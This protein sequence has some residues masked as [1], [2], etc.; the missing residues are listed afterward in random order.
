MFEGIEVQQSITHV[1][2]SPP[3][4]EQSMWLVNYPD[5]PVLR[6]IPPDF[7]Q[8]P[9]KARDEGG[10]DKKRG[11][12]G[13]RDPHWGQR[14]LFMNELELLTLHGSDGDVV[15]YAGAAPGKH[16]THLAN[17]LF[18]HINFVLV[19]PAPFLIKESDK[20]K[21]IN[22]LMTDEIAKEYAGRDNVVFVSDI[23]RT[24]ASE[25]LILEDMLDQ[26]RWHDIIR[27]KVGQ[28]KRYKDSLLLSPLH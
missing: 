25:D 23:R 7:P 26:Q 15:V 12:G 22:S 18:P 1:P 19:D 11:S 10:G 13:F 27:P 5:E 17:Q 28:E 8:R 9:Y 3:L 14:K 16:I 21:L 6:I 4:D 20:I 24:Y 2:V